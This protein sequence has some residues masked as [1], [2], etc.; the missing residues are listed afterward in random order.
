MLLLTV[1]YGKDSEDTLQRVNSGSHKN[2]TKHKNEQET[3]KKTPK[4]QKRKTQTGDKTN[5]SGCV[6]PN[7][8]QIIFITV[9]IKAIFVRTESIK[10]K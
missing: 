7:L 3:C 4:K 8:I 9:Q 5:N 10:I 1:C 6:P 2:K